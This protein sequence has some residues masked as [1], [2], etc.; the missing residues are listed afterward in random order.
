MGEG[1]VR[2]PTR[3]GPDAELQ[4]V[5]TWEPGARGSGRIPGRPRSRSQQPSSR[6]FLGCPGP[7]RSVL[8][9]L[10]RLL[11]QKVCGRTEERAV[12][13]DVCGRRE[14]VGVGLF[15]CLAELAGASCVPG[16]LWACGVEQRTNRTP[17]PWCCVLVEGGS[18][19]TDGS[20]AHC[21]GESPLEWQLSCPGVGHQPQ[22]A[23]GHAPRSPSATTEGQSEHSEAF[24]RHWACTDV[25]HCPRAPCQPLGSEVHRQ[26]WGWRAHVSL[27]LAPLAPGT[28]T[29]LALG[30]APL[31]WAL[32]VQLGG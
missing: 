9:S 25:G 31:F 11:I 27:P 2:S 1:R 16:L 32:H 21:L 22:R 17:P 14:S 29:H 6:C 28:P 4:R 10:S 13:A 19:V 20:A 23:L 15:T 18:R 26:A 24:Q 7:Q 8:W 3:R 12:G 5:G 30:L